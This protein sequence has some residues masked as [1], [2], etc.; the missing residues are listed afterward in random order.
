[1]AATAPSPAEPEA[2]PPSRWRFVLGLLVVLVAILLV[3]AAIELPPSPPPTGGG[4][5]PCTSCY[6]FSIVAGIGGTLT[7]NG[8][9]PGPA[10]TVPV[11]AQVTV[12]LIVSSSASGP[13]SWMLVPADG[14]SASSAVFPGANT[15]NP[16]VGNAPGSSQAVRF[17]AT[18]AGHYKYICGVDSHYL[19]MWGYFNVTA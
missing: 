19:D 6:S 2:S 9:T 8:T 12:T 4:A 17:A 5:P 1:M 15:T 13:H 11:D 10:M 18:A 16:S 3:A 14:T 7:F